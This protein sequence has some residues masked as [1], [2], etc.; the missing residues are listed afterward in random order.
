MAGR[1]AHPPPR[2]S[3]PTETVTWRHASNSSATTRSSLES[4]VASFR[5]RAH[6]VNY[7]GDEMNVYFSDVFGVTKKTL[8]RYG[9][10]NISLVTD[11][12][13]FIDPFLLFNSRK[14]EY[15]LLH[16]QMLD[17]LAFM[18]DEANAGNV[19]D[20]LLKSWLQFSEVKQ[21]WLGFTQSGNAGRGLG[22][23]FA[24]TLRANLQQ[25]FADFGKETVTKASHLEKLCLIEA[26]VGKDM[27]SRLLQNS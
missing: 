3:K 14:Q 23:T 24:R 6:L 17:Y 25:I 2:H 21:T 10:F 16:D 20:G 5:A 9:A 11:L 26:K 7:I 13:L 1:Q 27:I 4:H 22:I 12:P 8:E 19:S 15:Q 18:R